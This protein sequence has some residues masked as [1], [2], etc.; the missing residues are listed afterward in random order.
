MFEY[1]EDFNILTQDDQIIDYFL[2]NTSKFIYFITNQTL[3]FN[4]DI[5][6]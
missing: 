5:D 3:K 1:Y 2:I 6:I 4:S